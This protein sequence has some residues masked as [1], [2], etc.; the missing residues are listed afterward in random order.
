[1]D[2]DTIDLYQWHAPDPK[3][4]FADSVGLLSRLQEEGKIR[5]IGLSNVDVAQIQ[6][7][8]SIIE[9]TSVQNRCNPFDRKSF[10]NGVVQYCTENK[11]S[12]LP[13]SPVGGHRGV[14][15]TSDNEILVEIGRRLEMS[16]YEVCLTWLLQYS[17]AMLPIPGASRPQS[18]QSSFSALERHLDQEAL[19][20]MAQ[21]FP[22]DQ[23]A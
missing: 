22:T 10:E 17:S 6:E 16:P 20:L 9:V 3:V 11:I 12:F 14:G 8:Q 23:L 13:H 1:M 21:N 2:V 18:I 5:Y 7:A 15:R 4:T 19:D